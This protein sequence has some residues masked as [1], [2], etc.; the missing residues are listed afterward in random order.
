MRPQRA[1][2]RLRRVGFA[3]GVSY[4]VLLGIAMPLKY[5]AD[6]P[7]VVTWV[8]WIHGMLFVLFVAALAHAAALRRWRTPRIAGAFIA[9]LVPFGTFVLDRHLREELD[10]IGPAPVEAG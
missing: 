2:R 6:R 3:E 5:L 7:E 9:S 1:L 4:L 10:R 8:G